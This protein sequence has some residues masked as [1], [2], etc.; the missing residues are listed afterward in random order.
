[1]P[2]QNP[3]PPTRRPKA[4]VFT[5]FG[6][7]TRGN[8]AKVKRKPTKKVT[9]AHPITS[10]TTA[11]PSLTH[12]N[13]PKPEVAPIDHI[14]YNFDDAAREELGFGPEAPP[15]IPPSKNTPNLQLK[16]WSEN[17]ALAYLYAIYARDTAP[18]QPYLSDR[19][20]DDASLADL[21]LVCHLGHEGQQCHLAGGESS[22]WVGDLHGFSK[23][24]V[25][26]CV[27]PNA[28]SKAIQL[29]RAGIFACSDTEPQSGFTLNLLEHFTVFA[30]LGK[31]SGFRYYSVL[32]RLTSTGFP[33]TVA[34]RYQ[35]LMHT[36]RKYAHVVS[37]KRAGALYKSGRTSRTIVCVACPRPGVNFDPKEILAEERPFFRYW[38]AFDGNMRNGLKNKKVDLHDVSLTDGHMYFV[39]EG[40]YKEW[41]DSKEKEDTKKTFEEEKERAK[42]FPPHICLPSG[43]DLDGGV[44]RWHL[45][46]HIEQCKVEHSLNYRSFVGRIEGEGCERAWA[47][48]NE[49]ASSTSEKSPGARHDAINYIVNDWNFEKMV[50][51]VSKFQDAKKM[52]QR[53][54]GTFSE[55]NASLPK[56]CTDEWRKESIKPTP[57]QDGRLTSPFFGTQEWGKDLKDVLQSEQ[58]REDRE[59]QEDCEEHKHR[60]GTGDTISGGKRNRLAKWISKGIELENTMYGRDKLRTDIA[61]LKP[62][63]TFRQNNSINDR[64]KLLYSRVTAHRL[65]REQYLGSLG[66]PDHPK[67]ERND[68][69]DVEYSE[70]GLPSAYDGAT[71]IAANC[72]GA[73]NVE[74]RIRRAVC[75]DALGTARN[76]LGAKSFALR[77]KRKNLVGEVATTR[78]EAALKD[79]QSKVERARRRYNRSRAALLRLDL[80]GSD[81]TTYRMLET[82]D[83]KMLST[84]LEEE[85]PGVGQG[86]RQISWIWRSQA[87]TNND[88]WQIDA[89]RVEWFRARQRYIQWEEELKHLKRE[90][91]MCLKSFVHSHQEWHAKS[92][93]AGLAPGRVHARGKCGFG[94]NCTL[95]MVYKQ[96]AE[97]VAA[98]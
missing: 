61:D 44:P 80:L 29:L 3:P 90:T 67:R 30:T 33:S 97:R 95:P 76:L 31:T 27:H 2:Q 18:S 54:L 58:D 25:L 42:N 15:V 72:L 22:V 65:E 4:A 9:T 12:V 39:K 77:Y 91:V 47:Y 71:L 16:D 45:A 10:R 98:G 79:L 73:P 83:L 88:E 68:S 46:G 34:D 50:T 35:E 89:L 60:E 57:G 96:L 49:T 94:S 32:Q 14:F 21:G 64:R 1:M 41:L 26:Y 81:H 74:A 55:L 8:V 6:S 36:Q 78:A 19:R 70:L 87:A 52:Y 66:A 84:Y 56:D 62:D 48:L 13:P 69:P 37:L 7:D 24:R 93:E 23:L 85:S 5:H 38:F 40:P 92:Y 20:W 53:Q 59:D 51:I 28:P 11:G 17:Q 75:K 43:L 86:S 63:S 82:E